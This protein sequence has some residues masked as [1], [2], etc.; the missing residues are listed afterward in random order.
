MSNEL[1]INGTQNGCR[2]ALLKDKTLVEFHQDEGG[3][4]FSVGDIYLG[5]VKKVVQGLNAAFID[6][7]YDTIDVVFEPAARDRSGA[8]VEPDRA[9][10]AMTSDVDA[11]RPTEV[12]PQRIHRPRRVH[13]AR[14]RSD[15]E[16]PR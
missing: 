4:K 16:Q 5:S 9:R 7:G 12:N 10:V 3:S 11:R 13:D 15:E 14:P 8:P 2:I 6:V 1:I